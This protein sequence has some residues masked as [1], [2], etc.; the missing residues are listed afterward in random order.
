[1]PLPSKFLGACLTQ[2]VLN[3]LLTERRINFAQRQTMS[4]EEL[5]LAHLSGSQVEGQTI[6]ID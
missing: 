1:M 5:S 2:Q 3:F 6:L 4:Y